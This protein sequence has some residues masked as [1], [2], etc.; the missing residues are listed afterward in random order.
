MPK[1][2]LVE[3][4]VLTHPS[5]LE[6]I[7]KIADYPDVVAGAAQNL[8]PHRLTKY[9]Q[10]LAALFHVFYTNCRVLVDEEPLRQARLVLIEATRIT[11]RNLLG[12]IG[13]SAPERM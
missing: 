10:D 9:A 13:V 4:N 2:G 6:L 7:R 11:L 8:E 5:E 1:A 3:M 12:L